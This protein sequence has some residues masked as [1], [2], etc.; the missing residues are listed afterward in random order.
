[1]KDIKVIGIGSPFGDDRLG[2]E[3]A[4]QLQ[5]QE[6][7]QQLPLE[8]KIL[9]RPG[10][11]LLDEFHPQQTVLL[12]DAIQTHHCVGHLHCLEKE[13][14]FALPSPASSHAIGIAETLKMAE[15]LNM[16][17]EQLLLFA[18]EISADLPAHG[19]ISATINKQIPIL[20]SVIVDFILH[21]S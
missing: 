8:I 5:Q 14:L 9:D 6:S 10:L 4:K 17:P 15:A 2:W 18:I 3:A 13:A 21:R 11:R 1:M 12:I 20:V 16:L 7:L 19:E